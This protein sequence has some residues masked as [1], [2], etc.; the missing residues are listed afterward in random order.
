MSLIEKNNDT[1]KLLKKGIQQVGQTFGE[2]I[3][4]ELV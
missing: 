3:P 2:A 4:S 1:I